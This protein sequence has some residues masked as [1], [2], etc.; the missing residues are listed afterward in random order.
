MNRK[1]AL[2][3]FISPAIAL[4]TIILAVSVHDFIFTGNALSDMGRIGLEKNY[5]FNG[6][7]LMAGFFG[8]LFSLVF[9]STTQKYE[10]I[11]AL[12]FSLAALCLMGIAIFPEGTSPHYPFSVGFY[13]IATLSIVVYSIA[14]FRKKNHL[15]LFSLGMVIL[16]M[17]LSFGPSWEGVAIPETIG[18]LV[19]CTWIVL[20]AYGIWTGK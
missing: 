16:G 17:M 10:K 13:A 4:L 20:V 3:G 2:F 9:I 14:I 8:F 12:I 15:A 1:F 7:L 6:G 19:I 5:I 18:A 11:A